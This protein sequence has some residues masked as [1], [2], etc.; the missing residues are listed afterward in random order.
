[1]SQFS[2]GKAHK[3]NKTVPADISGSPS[4]IHENGAVLRAILDTAVDGI[5]IIDERGKI[6][7]FNRS[8][9]TLFGHTASEVLGQNVKMLMPEP[10][11]RKHDMYIA[12]Y[13]R[14][15]KA[16]IIGIG[17]EVEG[18]RK[19][20]TRFPMELSVSE[21]KTKGQRLFAGIARNISERK[22]AEQ[23][24]LKNQAE[25]K[26]AKEAAEAANRSKSEFLANMS[27]ELRTPLNGI[28]GYAQLLRNHQ[29]VDDVSKGIEIIYQCGEHLLSL[30]NDILD[31]A[32]IEARKFKLQP[33]EFDLQEF[34]RPIAD[35]TKVR[36]EVKNLNFEYEECSNLPV[37]VKCDQKILRQILLNLLGNA[38]KFTEKGSVILRVTAMN[39]SANAKTMDPKSKTQ[40]PMSRVL[41]EVE[42]TGIGIAPE[43]WAEIFDPFTQVKDSYEEVQG[44]GLGLPISKKL[45]KLLGSELK[46]KSSK[47]KGSI[48]WFELELP[49]IPYFIPTKPNS[50]K[51]ILKYKGKIRKILVVDDKQDNRAFLVN[52]LTSLGFDVFESAD[53]EDCLEKATQLKPDLI[54]MDLVMP[55]LDGFEATRRIRQSTE[56]KDV[57]VIALSASVF[58]EDRKRSLVSGCDDFIA[59]PFRIKQLLEKIEEH[60]GLEWVY[61]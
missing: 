51:T 14:T 20:G 39:G 52:L 27:H 40:S 58:D 22:A 49:V 59:K 33:S 18:L 4:R 2:K 61:G 32:K 54:F 10:D 36:A 11:S 21:I 9:E 38:I 28:L 53:G 30:I 42:D 7:S 26:K 43:H 34:L 45:V 1:M 35:I 29:K 55:V 24:I 23:K 8:A 47:G 56:L 25:L 15:G 12:N 6:R 19:N 41:F 37:G 16:N 5:I 44:T 50:E 60:L 3:G 48:F 46:V 13:L 57:I 17:R 31:L